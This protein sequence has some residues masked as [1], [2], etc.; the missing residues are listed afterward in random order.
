MEQSFKS[1]SPDKINSIEKAL[2]I[3]MV[4]REGQPSWGVRE[5]SAHLGFSPSTTQ[6]ILQILKSYGFVRQHPNTK[7]YCLGNIYL[8]FFRTLQDNYP[9]TRIAMPLIRRLLSR[10]GETAHFN[11]IDTDCV[12]RI[13]IATLESTLELKAGMPVGSKAPLYAGA[14]SKCLLAF[15]SQ[16]FIDSYLKK[17]KLEPL[18]NNTIT[19]VE[20]LIAELKLIRERGYAS[21]LGETFQGLGSLSV[22]IVTFHQGI[23]VRAS[24]SL[25]IPEVR[26]NNYDHRKMCIEEMLLA[27]KEFSDNSGYY[28]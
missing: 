16:D 28:T 18:T 27:S 4:F 22:P 2:M 11:I 15:S 14:S 9:I 10:T 17:V 5:L 24:A 25:A 21:S 8:S 6:R 23:P 3:L 12:S 19:D 20:Q 13:C 7:Q 26:F 1:H